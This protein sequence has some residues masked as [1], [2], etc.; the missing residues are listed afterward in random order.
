MTPGIE[1]GSA[2]FNLDEMTAIGEEAAKAGKRTASH[3]Q[4]AT[5]ILNAVKACVSSIEH[6]IFL[7]DEISELM[8]QKGTYLVPTLVAPYNI[9]LLYTSRCV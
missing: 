2:Q 4:G 9:C 6:G 8:L 3:A 7:T 5:G 1:P